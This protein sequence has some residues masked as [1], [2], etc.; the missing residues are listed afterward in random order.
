MG[1]HRIRTIVADDHAMMRNILTTMLRSMGVTN[2][3]LAASG[4]EAQSLLA[5]RE[6]DLLITDL[7]MDGGTGTEL[8]RWVRTSGQVA[9]SEMPVILV[10]AYSDL[11]RISAAR[12]AGVTEIMTKPLSAQMLVS[13]LVSV[14]D[15][16]RPFVISSVFCGPDRRRRKSGG[17]EGPE[18]RIG[19]EFIL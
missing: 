12:D 7:E 11:K 18:R 16:P 10:T 19:E 14:I 4:K 6:F 15:N 3:T 5:G 17:Y 13:R 8:T 1:L 9:W 2:V